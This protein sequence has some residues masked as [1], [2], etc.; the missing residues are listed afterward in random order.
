MAKIAGVPLIMAV[1]GAIAY[2]FASNPKLAEVGRLCLAAGL[3]CVAFAG[4][5]DNGKKA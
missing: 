1:V 4:M 5:F 3:F 2:W